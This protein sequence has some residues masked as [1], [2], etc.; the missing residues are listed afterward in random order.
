MESYTEERSTEWKYEPYN[1]KTSFFSVEI[2][3]GG[4]NLILNFMLR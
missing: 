4:K 3:S 2:L 1:G